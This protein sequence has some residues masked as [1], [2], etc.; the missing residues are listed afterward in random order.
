MLSLGQ[1][2]D[3]T[4]SQRTDPK[5]ERG[6]EEVAEVLNLGSTVMGRVWNV[7]EENWFIR[8]RIAR[9]NDVGKSQIEMD[10]EVETERGTPFGGKG[11]GTH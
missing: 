2:G 10:N 9:W 3:G 7:C 1:K 6:K 8:F 5:G 4:G 11:G